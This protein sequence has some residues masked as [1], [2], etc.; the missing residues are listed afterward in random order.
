MALIRVLIVDDSAVYRSQMRAALAENKRIEVV[1]SV[2]NGQEALEKLQSSPV[3]LVVLDMEMPVMD[4]LETLEQMKKTSYKGKIILFSAHT[5][6]GAQ[7]TFEALQLGAHDFAAKP[8]QWT[9]N[10]SPQSIISELLA[11]KIEA[12]FPVSLADIGNISQEKTCPELAHF[13]P[14]AIAIGASTGGPSVLEQILS[15]MSFLE[16]PIFIAQHMP[17]LF[18]EELARRLERISGLQVRLGKDG[19]LVGPR[20]VYVAPGN[21][22]MELVQSPKGIVIRTHQGPLEHFLRPAVDPLFRSFAS[23]YGKGGLGIV[24]TGMGSDGALGAQQIHRAGGKIIVQCKESCAVFGMPAAVI[25]MGLG[26]ASLS[27][28]EIRSWLKRISPF[29]DKRGA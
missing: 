18:I 28:L 5:Q 22:H 19:E 7:I 13:H 2:R 20:T 21:Y 26:D 14:R 29:R 1:A 15:E 24:L 27:P 3:D 9:E 12:L 16:A 25:K 23:V 17:P 10:K 11:P 8:G 4:G 6:K